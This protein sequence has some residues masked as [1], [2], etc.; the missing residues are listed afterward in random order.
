MTGDSLDMANR[1]TQPSDPPYDAHAT[2]AIGRD[3]LL[4]RRAIAGGV[5]WW[6]VWAGIAMLGAVLFR[7]VALDLYALS[8]E[9]GQLAFQGWAVFR[10]E[11][12]FEPGELPDTNPF[13]QLAVAL[14]LFLSGA[15][16]V[17]ARLAPVEAGIGM[18][19]LIFLLRPVARPAGVLGLLLTVGL[20]PSL[21]YFSRTIDPAIFLAFFIMLWIVAVVRASVARTS[22]R[23]VAWAALVGVAMAGLIAS[24]PVGIS[25]IVAGSIAEAIA[26][27]APSNERYPDAFGVGGKRVITSPRAIGA[28]VIALLITLGLFFTR[29]LSDPGAITGIIDTFSEW[30]RIIGTRPTTTPTQFFPW[31]TLLYEPVAVVLAVVALLAVPVGRLHDGDLLLRGSTFVTWFGVALVLQSLSSGRAP[32]QFVLISAPLVVAAGIGLGRLLERVERYR[33]LSSIAS[34][35]PFAVLALFV[36]LI[37]MLV[38]VARGNDSAAPGGD[39]T[40]QTIIIVLL[41]VMVP[42]SAILARAMGGP[43]GRPI[44]QWSVLLVLVTLLGIFGIRNASM[45]AFERAEEGTELLAQNTSTSGVTALVDQITRLSRD[46]SVGEATAIDPTGRFSIEIALDPDTADPFRWYF[47]EFPEVSVTGPAGW[48]DADVVIAPATASMAEQGYIVQ[49]RSLFNR[50]PPAY[51]T[52]DTGEILSYL[53]SPS[54]W[55]DGIRFLLFREE[56]A[57][58]PAEQIAVG[59]TAELTNQ[60]NPALGPF[61][62][63]DSPGR[64]SAL[65]QLD[66]PVG[67]AHSPDGNIIYVVNSNNLRVE[68]YTEEG[69]FIGVW[70]VETDPNLAFASAF[71]TGPTGITTGDEGLVY[72][73]DTWNHRVV[74]IDS[75]GQMVREIGQRGGQVN[76]NDSPDPDVETGFFFGPRDIAVHD[77]EIYVT[78][79]GNERVQVF[80]SDGTFL[81]AFGGFGSGPGQLVEPVGIAVGSDGTVYVADSG[82]NRLSIFESDG[83]PI[84]QVPVPSWEGQGQLVNYLAIGPDRLLYMTSPSDGTLDVYDPERNEI[85][86]STSG[87][88]TAELEQPIGVAVMPDGEVLVTDTALHGVVRFYPEIPEMPE[89]PAAV[90]ASPAASPAATPTD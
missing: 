60:I 15:T 89:V 5:S 28:L 8:P 73:A 42:F 86:L 11:G 78:D 90:I 63:T 59:Y 26:I 2:V 52:P 53:V 66:T 30:A 87:P 18:L 27:V 71:G 24:G 40:V 56:V 68:R 23:V 10:G 31:S 29:L 69:E 85:I 84:M 6:A 14:S 13:V 51:Q 81:R 54:E 3:D 21:V 32:E 16:D 77:S 80:A 57:T 61:N 62:L 45:L 9:E 72:V 35:V 75:N 39:T 43:H 33:L 79:T 7:I 22:G 67:V 37:A 76:L 58:P 88:E 4:D 64:G 46:V 65:G 83:T 25:A 48:D 49:T 55:Y 1:A 19:L 70:S 74:V 20:S 82:N 12:A 44:A 36:G 50:V 17:T 47:R 41:L 38:A 34:L